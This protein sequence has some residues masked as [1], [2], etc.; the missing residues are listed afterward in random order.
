MNVKNQRERC[1][2]VDMFY[3]GSSFAVLSLLPAYFYS[4]YVQPTLGLLWLLVSIGGFV[5]SVFAFLRLRASMQGLSSTKD[6]DLDER[7]LI[8][9]NRAYFRAYWALF[10]T[11]AALGLFSSWSR[12]CCWITCR[13]YVCRAPK[14]SS[15]CSRSCVG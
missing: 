8:V 11:I 15:I 12:V 9:R 7:Q 1:R 2:L 6:G 5:T 3:L 13:G 4:G 14:A 10:S